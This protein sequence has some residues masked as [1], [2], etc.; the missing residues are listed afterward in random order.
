MENAAISMR[1]PYYKV[2][3]SV[4]MSLYFTQ[5]HLAEV[6]NILQ[7]LDKYGVPMKAVDVPVSSGGTAIV[8]GKLDEIVVHDGEMI[9]YETMDDMK[10]H[11]VELDID[12]YKLHKVMDGRP[13]GVVFEHEGREYRI[14]KKL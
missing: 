2:S 4:D 6:Q 10:T 14:T 13:I 9:E 5:T 1:E 11:R 8:G 12:R 3:A 7:L